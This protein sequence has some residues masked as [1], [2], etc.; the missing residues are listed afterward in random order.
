MLSSEWRDLA[1]LGSYDRVRNEHRRARQQGQGSA[2]LQIP[3]VDIVERMI[4]AAKNRV[5]IVQEHSKTPTKS[6]YSQSNIPAQ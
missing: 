5:Q 3:H 1:G 6:E 2:K 4:S